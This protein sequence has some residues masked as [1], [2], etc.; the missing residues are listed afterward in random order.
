MDRAIAGVAFRRANDR[1]TIDFLQDKLEELSNRI[2]T[3]RLRGNSQGVKCSK[4]AEPSRSVT[5]SSSRRTHSEEREK[6]PRRARSDER[7]STPPR[8]KPRQKPLVRRVSPK[9]VKRLEYE[10][11]SESSRSSSRSRDPKHGRPLRSNSEVE[12]LKP[13]NKRLI[14]QFDKD[15]AAWI[16]KA[17]KERDDVAETKKRSSRGDK[18]QKTKKRPRPQEKYEASPRG[19]EGPIQDK[20]SPLCAKIL[21]APFPSGFK[22]PNFDK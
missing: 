9:I 1:S 12:E 22:Y 16:A 2:P 13:R 14:D 8:H 21:A 17:L 11:D 7:S 3:E 19:E 6:T 10:E 15:L 18:K 4:D 5:T 20:D